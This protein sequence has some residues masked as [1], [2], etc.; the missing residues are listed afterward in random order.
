MGTTGK[1]IGGVVLTAA[2]GAIAF[3]AIRQA[4]A[5]RRRREQLGHRADNALERDFDT[6]IDPHEL[7]AVW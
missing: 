7:M 3:A 4:E 6:E 5:D 2:L 1:L